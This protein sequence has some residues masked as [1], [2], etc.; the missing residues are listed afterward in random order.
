MNHIDAAFA[1]QQRRRSITM[2][3]RKK[4]S[5]EAEFDIE[6]MDVFSVERDSDGDTRF[7]Y[8]QGET[9]QEW[10]I[11]TTETQHA[12]FVQRLTNKLKGR[13]TDGNN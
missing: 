2:S 1:A 9:E 6:G 13:V 4:P 3:W 8:R 7:G 11:A 5:K 12:A 10:C